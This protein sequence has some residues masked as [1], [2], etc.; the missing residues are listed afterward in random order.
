MFLHML[1]SA[2]HAAEM[3]RLPDAVIRLGIRS[4][5]KQRDR[6]LRTI[7]QEERRARFRRFVAECRRSP[8]ALVPEQAN[9]QHYEVP[10]DFFKIVLG[11][12]LKYSC[13][14]WPSGVRT[15]DEAEESSLR[16][17]CERAGIEDG[18]HVLELGCGW[19]SLSLWMAE[20]YPNIRVAAVSNSR[21]Q[22]AYIENQA[23]QRGLANLEVV[24]ADMNHFS[25]DR[26]FDRVVSIEMFEHMRNHQELM[27]RIST[28]LVPSGRLFVHIF[29]HREAP[30]LFEAEGAHNWMG[31][32][33]FSGGM[34]PSAGLLLQ[35]QHDLSLVDRWSWNGRH[36]E[37]T[38][39]AW[40]S[41]QDANR[42]ALQPFF[43]HTYGKRE[44]VRWR[45]R[46]RI[47]FMAC[48]E[49]FGYRNGSEWLVAHYLFER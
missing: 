35:Y 24:T 5:L 16:V 14:H 3:G 46:W 38:C 18:M 31:R 7:D 40:L 10:A 23:R 45:N 41:R 8:I 13:C 44:A 27:R 20:R 30:Y 4:L 28:W 26:S 39:N 37:R 25:T 22:R 33:F 43:E 9:E 47:F 34:M 48:A 6:S 11:S 15:L 21:S 36:Y 12:R 17:T 32:E 42:A 1:G 29:C 2:I 49:L 19:G